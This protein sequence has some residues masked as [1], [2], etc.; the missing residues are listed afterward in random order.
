MTRDMTRDTALREPFTR[1]QFVRFFLCWPMYVTFSLLVVEALL[2][3]ATTWFV[4]KAGR[5]V[6]NGGDQLVFDLIMI[7]VVGGV[8]SRA[9][10]GHTGRELRADALTQFAYLF[11]TI[12]ALLRVTAPLGLVEYRLGMEAAGAAW[13][14]AFLCFLAAYG[15]MLFRPRID[16]KL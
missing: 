15:P 5:D 13:I 16:G 14:A 7:L 8:M 3:A 2:S 4:I 12:G 1:L 10:L 11:V 6:A 9:I